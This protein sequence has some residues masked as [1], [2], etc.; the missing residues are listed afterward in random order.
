MNNLIYKEG[1]WLGKKPSL[2]P[3]KESTYSIETFSKDS[4]PVGCGT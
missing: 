1:G 2:F 3:F 4:E